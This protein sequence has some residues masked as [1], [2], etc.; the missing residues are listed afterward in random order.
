[1]VP[2]RSHSYRWSSAFETHIGKVRKLNEDAVLD[3]PDIG[4][5]AV[6]DGMGGHEGG[7]R[8]SRMV[9]DA[10]A[11][12]SSPERLGDFVD[13]AVHELETVNARLHAEARHSAGNISGSTVVALLVRGRHGVAVWAGD[14]RIYLFRN[15]SLHALSRDHSQVEEWVSN[16]LLERHQA[17][18]HPGANVI[19][20]AIGAADSV[21]LDTTRFEILPNDIYLLCSDGLYNEVGEQAMS[22][23][24]GAG[25]CRHAAQQLLAMALAG[26]ARDNISL[27]IT[28]ADEQ[29]AD[30]TRTIINPAFAGRRNLGEE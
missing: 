3:R 13:A 10:L 4:L 7:D 21:E 16:G 24:L 25:D 11:S 6:A 22:H 23:T 8:A 19:T 18:G 1:M 20:R 2:A 29:V 26:E 15:G 27:V 30:A 12:L 14:S 5:W 28:R 17:G 9:V